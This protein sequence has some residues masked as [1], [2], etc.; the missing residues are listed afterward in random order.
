MIAAS[1]VLAI[2]TMRN[3]STRSP[4]EEAGQDLFLLP[5]LPDLM[6][7]HLAE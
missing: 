3:G 2:V 1:T 4:A 6:T 5:T 7:S